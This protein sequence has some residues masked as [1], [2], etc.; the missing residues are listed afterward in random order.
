MQRRLMGKVLHHCHPGTS[1]KRLR[2]PRAPTL[3]V[4]LEGAKV[5]QDFAHWD[6]PG[7]R[8]APCQY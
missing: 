6:P 4:D 5:V 8:R 2:H 3:N 7:Q 1:D